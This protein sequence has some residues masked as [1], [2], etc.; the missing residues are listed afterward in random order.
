[1]SHQQ[2]DDNC[3]GCQPALLDPKT[4]QVMA[5]NHPVMKKMME[6]WEHTTFEQRKAFHDVCCNNSREPHDLLLMD[7]I[8]KSIQDALA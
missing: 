3:K 4:G 8:L 7:Q 1:M 2:F 6:V 5:A